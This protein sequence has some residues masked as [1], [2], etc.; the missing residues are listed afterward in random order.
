MK[1]NSIDLKKIKILSLAFSKAVLEDILSKQYSLIFFEIV[2]KT[3]L[4]TQLK[5]ETYFNIFELFFDSLVKNYRNEYVYKNAIASKIVRGRHKFTASYFS[6]FRVW[7]SIADAVVINGTTTAYEIKTEYDSFARLESQLNTYQ[8]VFEHVYV[9]IPESKRTALEIAGLPKNIGVIVLTK[10][11]S[12]SKDRESKS[13]IEYFSPDMLF[14]CLRK[15]EYESIVLKYYGSLP[16]VKPVYVRRECAS[17]FKKLDVD[18]VHREF[19][20]SLKS[21]NNS[22][23]KKEM[24]T[25][26]P[27]SLLSLGMTM[28]LPNLKLATLLHKLNDKIPI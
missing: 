24:L 10:N 26:L 2:K 19:L 11:Y 21:R 1:K 28:D 22:E 4:Y 25:L 6:E 27:K 13:N 7:D 23:D 17:L 16:E 12:L 18:I 14:S 15:Q 8:K 5:D 9:V 20:S 3:G